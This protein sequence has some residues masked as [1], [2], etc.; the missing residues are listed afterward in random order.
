MKQKQIVKIF[1]NILNIFLPL[2]LIVKIPKYKLMR[3]NGT[4]KLIFLLRK[5]GYS[6]T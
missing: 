5:V 1:K 6:E 2:Y 3:I 4:K